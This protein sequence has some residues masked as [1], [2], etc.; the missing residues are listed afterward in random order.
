MLIRIIFICLFAIPFVNW[1]LRG[2]NRC[3]LPL[4]CPITN[5]Y[6]TWTSRLQL[7]CRKASSPYSTLHLLLC[8]SLFFL[9]P[10]AI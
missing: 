2:A 4:S 5:E 3:M 9:I 8:L 7:L 6:T 1:D 10:I